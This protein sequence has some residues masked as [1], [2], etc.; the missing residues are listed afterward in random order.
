MK[1]RWRHGP[2]RF[3]NPPLDD[4]VGPAD[5]LFALPAIIDLE[6]GEEIVIY[7]RD[8]TPFM[9]DLCQVKPFRLMVRPGVGRNQFGPVGFL[10]FWVPNPGEPEK[11]FVA[12]DV[13]LNPHDQHILTLWRRLAAQSHWH[14]LLIGNGNVQRGFYEFENT[15]NLL[16]ALDFIVQ[17]CAP[18][19]MVDFAKAAH[20][21]MQE[22]SIEDLMKPPAIDVSDSPTA[23]PV[24]P[25]E[26]QTPNPFSSP[27]Y[28]SLRAQSLKQHAATPDT[29]PD[30]YLDQLRSDL[31]DQLSNKTLIYLDTCHWINIRHVMLQSPHLKEPY[32]RILHLLELLR[33]KEKILCPVSCPLF[34]ELMKQTDPQSRAATANLMDYLSGGVCVQIWIDLVRSEWRHHIASTLLRKP[35]PGTHANIFTKAG[36]WAGE[37]LIDYL[38][39]PEHENRL[40]QKLYIDLRWAMSFQDYQLLPGW[41]KTPEVLTDKFVAEGEQARAQQAAKPQPYSELL[42][43]SR[44]ALFNSLKQELISDLRSIVPDTSQEQVN[45]DLRAVL[46]TVIENPTP[47][48]MPSLQVLAGISATVAYSRRKTKPNDVHD[49]LHAGQAIPYCDAFFCDNPIAAL[50]REKPL[51]YHKAYDTVILSRPEEIVTHLEGILA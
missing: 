50:L 51:E 10:L 26:G 27:R 12:Y 22:H 18:I 16:D 49:F 31:A 34:E 36:F 41:T 48:T 23:K 29:S 40:R 44:L 25:A 11:H 7:V 14:V 4:F 5:G 30:A 46:E 39:L 6:I 45:R 28:A 17:A 38:S 3:T 19:Q 15:F 8:Q 35:S 2:T 43:G 24:L 47:W 32:D 42:L 9:E 21:F 13:Y 37:H 1:N 20:Q 33:R